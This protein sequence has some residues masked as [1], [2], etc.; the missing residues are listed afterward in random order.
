VHLAR[1]EATAL[2]R[3]GGLSRL[4]VTGFASVTPASYDPPD[5]HLSPPFGNKGGG[6]K[7]RRQMSRESRQRLAIIFCEFLIIPIFQ[8][9]AH[10][11]WTE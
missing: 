1:I 10:L 2:R 5:G 3:V 9:S 11:T 4:T 7:S 6:I 8:W